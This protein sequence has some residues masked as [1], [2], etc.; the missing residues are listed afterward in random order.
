MAPPYWWWDG[1]YMARPLAPPATRTYDSLQRHEAIALL[2][3]RT[4]FIR[5]NSRLHSVGVSRVLQRCACEW[6]AQTVRHVMIYC[7]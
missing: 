6:D 4:E 5:L 3:L 1:N 2:L 7:P